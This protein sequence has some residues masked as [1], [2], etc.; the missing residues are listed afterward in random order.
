MPTRPIPA[1]SGIDPQ[2][3]MAID[4]LELRAR[5]VVE[6][7]W[8]GLHRS[9]YRGFSVEF[10]EYRQYTQ[11]DDLRHLD[12]KALARTDREYLKVYEEES[13]LR[14]TILLDASRSMAFASGSVTKFNYARTLVATLAYFLRQ[15]RDMVGLARFS[16][17]VEDFIEPRWRPGHFRR[18]L[19]KLEAEPTNPATDF[20]LALETVAQ[21]CR[22]RGLIVVFSDFLASPEPWA[23]DLARLA[24]AGHDLRIVQI[25]DP[26]E[27]SLD[28]GKA[29]FWEDVESGQLLYVDPAVA[30]AAY[31]IRFQERREAVRLACEQAGASYQSVS[32]DQPLDIALLSIIRSSRQRSSKRRRLL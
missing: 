11:G 3:L 22:R 25:L 26:A 5:V 12:W 24:A 4:D 7:M 18:L 19:T 13:N 23:T 6:G 21:L 31:K 17:G 10:S 30:A 1:H 28:F 29:A 9:P 15:Q 16:A 32:T 2:A 27:I 8:K 20:R 14:C